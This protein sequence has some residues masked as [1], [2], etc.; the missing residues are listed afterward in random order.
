MLEKSYPKAMLCVVGAFFVTASCVLADGA[1]P[2]EMPFKQVGHALMVNFSGG[3]LQLVL[4]GRSGD[5]W[6]PLS[7]KYVTQRPHRTT[8][9]RSG[10]WV[11]VSSRGVASFAKPKGYT[12]G[13]LRVMGSP[14]KH[15]AS[16]V[17]R[18]KEFVSD[19][20][21]SNAAGREISL[22]TSNVMLSAAQTTVADS[23]VTGISPTIVESDIW[24]VIG[25]QVFF[26]NQYRGL[27]VFD[28]SNPATPVRTGSLRLPASGEQFFALD[29]AGTKL[30]LLGRDTDPPA[31]MSN[32]LWWYDGSYSV[33]VLSVTDG[34]P[35]LATKLPVTGR[36]V[37]SRFIGSRLYLLTTQYYTE[38]GSY[39][40]RNVVLGFDFANPLQPMALA[41]LE[42]PGESY[43]VLQASGDT[44][45]VASTVWNW[46]VVTDYTRDSYVQVVDIGG[47][48]GQPVLIKTLHTKGSVS[49]KFKLN[50]A[51][52]VISAVSN[53]W[54][55]W[56][57]PSQTWVE[58]FSARGEATEPLGQLE[59][60]QARGESLHATRFDGDRVYVV[61]FR[62]IDPLFVVDL[63]NPAAPSLMGHV[64]VL[65][66]S[67]YI[68]PFGDRLLTVGVEQS[69]VT[70]SLFDVSNPA[71]PALLSRVPLG[72]D[73][74]WSEAN[75]DEKAVGFFPE[76]GVLLVPYQTM[77]GGTW[78]NA[79]AVVS[80]TPSA[81]SYQSSIL[82]KFTARRA[83]LAGENIISISGQ[84]MLVESATDLT[85]PKLLA[86]VTLSWTVDRVLPF[87]DSHLIQLEEGTN[88]MGYY[89]GFLPVIRSSG[90]ER[91][92]MLRISSAD[93]PDALVEEIHMGP[94]PAIGA[95]QKG[96]RLYV[97]QFVRSDNDD[98]DLIR[99]WVFDTSSPPALPVVAN[100]DSTLP[101]EAGRLNVSDALAL[102]PDDSTLVWHIPTYA[103]WSPIIVLRSV[104]T[105]ALAAADSV[106]AS[107]Q[108]LSVNSVS[109]TSLSSGKLTLGSVSS[110]PT[111]GSRTL[112][113]SPTASSATL[114]L[115]SDTLSSAV[116]GQA[117]LNIAASAGRLSFYPW[118]WNRSGNVA[119][120]VCPVSVDPG[121]TPTALETISIGGDVGT[122]VRTNNCKAFA[123][124][125]FVFTSYV[126]E[127]D[128][129][130][131]GTVIFTT[132]SQNGDASNAGQRSRPWLQVLDFR[133]PGS[134]VVRDRVSIPGELVSVSNVDDRGAIL[135]TSNVSCS[136]IHACAYDGVNAYKVDTWTGEADLISAD[137]AGRL[138]LANA[139]ND[140]AVTSLGFDTAT[141]KLK[142]LGTLTLPHTIYQMHVANGFLLTSNWGQ[143]EATA[144][145]AEG[146]FGSMASFDT[147]AQL[148]IQVRRASIVPG[149]GIWLPVSAYGVE[150][151]SF[152]DLAA[153]ASLP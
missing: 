84:E 22:N 127:P 145:T 87:G 13:Q 67:T 28:I 41:P 2:V 91:D 100:V 63:S 54:G 101:A 96:G 117:T 23:T 92:A 72:G 107:T 148:W 62:R 139:W 51:D 45:L 10:R 108:S 89:G 128:Y 38:D 47:P 7:V 40:P 75:Y 12:A 27:Q 123:A 82:H 16:V 39:E 3:P 109:S 124:G 17:V 121:G 43:P 135:L 37:D 42:L 102:W 110:T 8:V 105:L 69:K 99:T 136:H 46:S 143:V 88:R 137:A 114:S 74:S 73:Y 20:A 68:E 153:A 150:F 1:P 151:L 9:D 11:M 86:E 93:D 81:V 126:E 15:P 94:G 104:N 152:L 147:P 53:V 79:T 58:T 116:A 77:T 129:Y 65:G 144:I 142:V 48:D 140:P 111:V 78:Q 56:N 44:L 106:L 14:A 112:T 52:G 76:R 90:Y 33:F 31:G 49:D 146:D 132:T 138:F 125:G 25:N 115:A 130:Y 18:Q 57:R 34:T 6:K 120:V 119:A 83:A 118:W 85:A 70:V 36:V 55:G 30:A 26:F 134:P 80:V 50:V 131:G 71:A 103:Y 149:V 4:E 98:A 141:S 59:I 5:G 95:V 19:A 113:S 64:E 97:A 66:W 133:T 29:A 24:K 21:D 35:S 122:S 61:T 60:V 32:S